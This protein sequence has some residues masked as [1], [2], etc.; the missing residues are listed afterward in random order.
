MLFVSSSAVGWLSESRQVALSLVA[1]KW[2][3]SGFA[4]HIFNELQLI[5]QDVILLLL[6][7]FLIVQ[8]H[9]LPA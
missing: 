5:W 2:L 8:T 3:I 7:M 9:P 1:Q 6:D 4:G